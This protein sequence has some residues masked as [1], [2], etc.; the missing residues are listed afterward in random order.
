MN[1]HS[2]NDEA[3]GDDRLCHVIASDGVRLD[4]LL[5]RTTA[6]ANADGPS[7]DLYLLLHG[8]GSNFYAAGVLERFAHDALV[9]GID[10][11]RVNT[12]GHDGISHL[13]GPGKRRTGGAAFEVVSEC[14]LDVS[15][16]LDWS[17]HCGYR[18]VCLAGHSMG[19][20]KSVY[21]QAYDRHPL[22]KAVVAVS[23]P[24]F[25][26]RLLMSYPETQPF[27]DDWQRAEQFVARG[28]GSELIRVTQPLPLWITAEGFL[29]KYGPDDPYDIV[30]WI[31]HV[32]CP[33]Q[34]IIGAQTLAASPAF[35]GID[36]QLEQIKPA[37][38]DL[39]VSVV[40][41]A[42]MNYSVSREKPYELTATW[43]RESPKPEK[44]S[45]VSV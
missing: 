43:L 8:T 36:G 45:G 32:N 42:D 9:D 21:A 34:Y 13:G 11:L 38:H 14:R 4:G 25:C 20:V 33:V 6:K 35:F 28:E 19:G 18:R 31:P 40:A 24:R 3:L 23:S 10:V 41:D 29:A 27:R 5:Q 44:E 2:A 17:F 22:V 1:Q 12:R 16:W 39:T 37:C 30:K 26:H 15:A 7:V